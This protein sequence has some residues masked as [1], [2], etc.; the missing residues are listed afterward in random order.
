MTAI[1]FACSVLSAS[2]DP[3]KLRVKLES[4]S[5]PP[6]CP[7]NLTWIE[8][9]SAVTIRLLGPIVPYRFLQP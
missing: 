4:N 9:S 2:A 7:P 8:R 6:G 3:A 1:L 5:E